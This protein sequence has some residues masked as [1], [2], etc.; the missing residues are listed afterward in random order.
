MAGQQPRNQRLAQARVRHPAP[1]DP[2]HRHRIASSRP[3]S[4]DPIRT[5]DG[6]DGIQDAARAHPASASA[7]QSSDVAA[8]LTSVRSNWERVAGAIAMTAIFE[9][10]E[11]TTSNLHNL[12]RSLHRR[13]DAGLPLRIATGETRLSTLNERWPQQ[14]RKLRSC[15]KTSAGC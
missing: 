1:Q 7:P 4:L 14:R 11:R 12:D 9:A 5:Q 15:S 2:H 10:L 13:A 6:T 8:R 3:T